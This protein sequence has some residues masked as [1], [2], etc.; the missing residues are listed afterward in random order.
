MELDDPRKG[1]TSVVVMRAAE[2]EEAECEVC[3]E[4]DEVTHD[5]E[6]DV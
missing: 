5:Q 4:N 1:T 2:E 3:E 6:D